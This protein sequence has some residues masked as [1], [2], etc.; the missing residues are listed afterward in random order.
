[1]ERGYS[2]RKWYRRRI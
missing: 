1:M 2:Q